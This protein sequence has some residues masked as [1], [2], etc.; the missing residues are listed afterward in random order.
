MKLSF[1]PLHP[2]RVSLDSYG[3]DVARFADVLHLAETSGQ[4]RLI[5]D[6][7]EQRIVCYCDPTGAR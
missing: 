5:A 7:A 6:A 1:E 4:V 2:W 3:E